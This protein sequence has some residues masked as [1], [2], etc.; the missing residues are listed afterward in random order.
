M[1]ACICVLL[2][3]LKYV[4][5]IWRLIQTELLKNNS[6]VQL[7][8]LY[9][10]EKH[11]FYA[12]NITEREREKHSEIIIIHY[13]ENVNGL[14]LFTSWSLDDKNKTEKEKCYNEN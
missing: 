8:F 1:I 13:L 14:D 11:L 4:W 2:H 12:A 3:A 6:H 9:Q 5:C 7:D 10:E